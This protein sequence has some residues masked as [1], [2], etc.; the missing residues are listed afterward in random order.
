MSRS[1]SSRQWL[2]AHKNDPYVKQSKVEGYRSRAVY[3]L[4]EVDQKVGLIKAGMT[5]LELGAA[6]GGWTQYV[7]EKLQGRGTIVAVDCLLM[8]ALPEITFIQGDF[9]EESVQEKI[10]NMLGE[11]N[12]DVLLSDMAPN[13]SGVKAIDSLRTMALAEIT[14]EA[15]HIFLKPGGSMFMKLF[16]GAGFDAMIRE[17][18]EKFTHVSIRKPAASRSQSRET[19]LLALGYRL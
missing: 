11:R 10:K 1:K 16:H 19:Y 3:K 15:A 13:L 8:D 4:K 12:A 2:T 6:P 9:T 17:V 5:I 14:L 7:T 18:R